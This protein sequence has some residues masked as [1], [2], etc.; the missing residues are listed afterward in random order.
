MN[1][2]IDYDDGVVF[3]VVRPVAVGHVAHIALPHYTGMVKAS[4]EKD[5][6]T[7][8]RTNLIIWLGFFLSVF[9][10]GIFHVSI[11][12]HGDHPVVNTMKN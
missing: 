8:W 5:L 10:F 4:N 11:S 1:L 7:K 6:R 2:S 3:F 12:A 9:L